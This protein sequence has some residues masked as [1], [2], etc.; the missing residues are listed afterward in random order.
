MFEPY[1]TKWSLQ[2]DGAPI[3]TSGSDL[4]PVRHEGLP[5]MLKIA[6]DSEEKVGALLMCWP[7]P[8]CRR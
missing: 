2:L 7:M 5:A 6:R 3:R 4:L 8:G 1:M